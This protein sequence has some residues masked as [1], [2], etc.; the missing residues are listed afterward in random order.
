M[1][2]PTQPAPVI[3]V[4]L[5]KALVFERSGH[6]IRIGDNDPLL[7][8]VYLN[9]AV[10]GEALKKAEQL[11]GGV[12]KQL[13]SLPG[14][15]DHEMKRAASEALAGL[16]S[17]VVKIANQRA[18]DAAATERNT[19][20]FRAILTS[21]GGAIACIFIGFF[22]GL[23]WNKLAVTAAEAKANERIEQAEKDIAWLKTDQGKAAKNLAGM[24]AAVMLNECR[25]PGWEKKREGTLGL[26]KTYCYPWAVGGKQQS[27][28]KI[29]N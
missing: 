1:A 16:A 29:K 25:A 11:Q 28:W 10:L 5:L 19:A 7:A 27:G 6:K 21:V 2:T 17:E 23:G 20:F 12:T 18:G 4:D 26:G 24:D 14:A 8:T 13:Q 22:A 15:A 3:S 9:E